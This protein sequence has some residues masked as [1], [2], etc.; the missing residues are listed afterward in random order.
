MLNWALLKQPVNWIIVL[1]MVIIGGVVL[2]YVLVPF[3]D[4]TPNPAE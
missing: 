2:R 4:T 3:I 1:A